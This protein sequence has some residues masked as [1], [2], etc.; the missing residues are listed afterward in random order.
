MSDCGKV[1]RHGNFRRCDVC[2]GARAALCAG[3]LILA[4]QSVYGAHT[5]RQKAAIAWQSAI[6]M[7]VALETRPNRPAADYLRV[8]RAFQLVY[9][10]DPGYPKT[11]AALAAAAEVYEEMGRQFTSDRYYSDAVE[12]CQFLA[13]QYP[14]GSLASDALFTAA[15]IYRTDIENPQQAVAAYQQFL[16]AYPRSSRAAEARERMESASRQLARWSSQHRPPSAQ[17]APAQETQNTA[18]EQPRGRPGQ[19]QVVDGIR[20]WEGPNYT[21]VVI[22]AGGAVKFNA[23]HLENP[24]RLV[25]DL[26]DARLSPAL[27]RK[28]FPVE[29]GFLQRIRVA[30]FKPGITRVVLD[31]PQI[32]DYS[33]FSLPNPFRLV[34]DIH[35]EQKALAPRAQPSGAEAHTT[36]LA[37]RNAS[38]AARGGSPGAPLD[39]AVAGRSRS[40][41][42][43]VAVAASRPAQLAGNTEPGAQPSSGAPSVAVALPGPAVLGSPTL[44]RAL[45]LKIRR[46]VIDPGHGG[47][48]TG[49]IGPTGLEEKNV[50]LDVALKLRKLIVRRMACQVI[51]TRST[52][53][54]VPLEERTAI[55]NEYGADLFISIHAN[56]SRDPS[57]RGIEAYFLN[58]TSDPE[59]LALAARENATSRESVYQLQSLIKKIALSEK[60]GESD[61]FAKDIDRQLALRLDEAG[62]RQP[63]RGVKKAP[64]VVLIGANM[65]SVLAEISFLSNPHDERLLRRASYREKIAAALYSGIARY[66]SSLGT[67]RVAQQSG[68]AA[69]SPAVRAGGDLPASF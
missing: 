50:V 11:P 26:S 19:L 25:F 51:M 40:L 2:R 52:D 56:A 49:T 35:G 3:V 48:D 34:I 57:A 13:A 61:E 29:S 1:T 53:V 9:R 24:P 68:P 10:I 36:A 28:V 39:G 66:A 31:V 55:A 42:P 23:L 67:I 65:P 17:P 62:Y 18:A 60:I 33:V 46:I 22:R 64:F 38:L 27:A 6:R 54:F 41:P 7:R 45:G 59:A 16:A 8:V 69:A 15:E 44:T 32:E 14:H 4:C 21:R 58:F 63:N 47:H 12:A 43:T 30:Q 5:R 37:S 20:D